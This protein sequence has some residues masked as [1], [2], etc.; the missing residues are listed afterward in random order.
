MVSFIISI[1]N[2]Y[3]MVNNFFELFLQDSFVKS[4]EVVII[5]DGVSN[6][7]VI[8]YCEQLE[9]TNPNLILLK[10]KKLGFGVA[11]NLAVKHSHGDYLFFINCDVFVEKKCFEKLYASLAAGKAD[12]VQP[13]LIYPQTNLVQCAGTFF[14]PYYKDHLFDGNKIDAPIVQKEGYRQALT[15]AL[16]AMTK[17]V[18]WK[19]GGF[20]EFYFNK[21]ESFELSYKIFLG[22]QKCLYL[23][24]A[25]AWHSRGGG[26]KSYSFDFRQ[27]ESYFWTRFGKKIK[28]DLSYYIN[29]QLDDMNINQTYYAVGLNQLRTWPE[30]LK[31]TYICIDEFLEMPW[32]APGA[33]NLW[34]IFPH[35]LQMYKGNLLLL[36]ENIQYLTNNLYWFE[37]RNN[38]NDIAID[39]YANVV[40]IMD[41]LS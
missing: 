9:K 20:D 17:K 40:N 39:R 5:L 35:E 38:P 12:C 14:G 3:A 25:K 22:G 6:Q 28:E 7:N 41:Y 24:S 26:R 36:L 37:L 30:I 1:D 31:K 21:L 15:S 32:I 16:Y 11:N 33:F 29:L 18:F 4:H 13:L 10:S 27:Q 2:T 23:P 8:A 19:Y 34:D